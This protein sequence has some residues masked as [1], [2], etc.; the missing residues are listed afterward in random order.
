MGEIW[1]NL[2]MNILAHLFLLGSVLPQ[3]PPSEYADTEVSAHHR[4]EQPDVGLHGLDFRL[5]FNGTSSN[6]VE[7]AFGRDGNEDGALAPHETDVVV[8]WECGRYFIERFRT[9][10]RIEEPNVGTNGVR[11][12]LDWHYDVRKGGEVFRS[13]SATN[14]VGAA[15]VGL[16]A[17]RPDWLY[18][19][20]WNLMRLTA[21]G[22]DVQD[23]RFEVEVLQRGFFIHLR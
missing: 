1:Y 9:G 7:V 2:F 23:E 13:F 17:S 5:D 12:T 19:R 4:L 10:E 14:E 20:D 6:N 15:F 22:V 16:A 18:G 8:G 21:R 11:R 3:L